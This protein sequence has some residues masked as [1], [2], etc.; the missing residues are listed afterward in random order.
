MQ[1]KIRIIPESIVLLKLTDEEYFNN[2]TDYMSNSRLS[3]I[4]SDEGGDFSNFNSSFNTEYSDSFE[5]GTAIHSM[6]LQPD[7]YLIS[8]FNKPSGKF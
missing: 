8:D 5:L 1:S 3:L 6:I 7:S 2:Y 4:N